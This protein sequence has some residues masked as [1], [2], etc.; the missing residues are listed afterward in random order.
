MVT[1]LRYEFY[2]VYLHYINTDVKKKQKKM[3]VQ[4]FFC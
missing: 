3:P 1:T 2:S 4:M